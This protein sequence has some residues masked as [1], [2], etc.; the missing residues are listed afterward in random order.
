MGQLVWDASQRRDH[1]IAVAYFDQA[2][3]AARHCGHRS[4]EGLAL[5]RKSFVALYGWRN[6]EAG[7]AFTEHA[8][9]TTIGDQP[10]PRRAGRAPC[11]RGRRHARPP[12][13]L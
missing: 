10:H 12:P 8:A 13:G 6:P 3:V 4:A 1:D 11:G 5:L 7:L 9:R 2:A